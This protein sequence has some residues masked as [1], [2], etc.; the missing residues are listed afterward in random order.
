MSDTL[1]RYESTFIINAAIEESTIEETVTKFNELLK[2]Q[3][4]EILKLDKVGR[5]RLAYPIQK[6]HSGYY[7]TVEFKSDAK[8]VPVFERALQLD[9]YILRYLTI[10]VDKKILNSREQE[11]RRASV[12]AEPTV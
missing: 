6:K 1:N 5:K 2:E 3:N 7:V 4:A 9:D 11:K 12:E 10:Q 8:V